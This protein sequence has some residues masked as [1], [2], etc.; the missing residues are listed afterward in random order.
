MKV[1]LIY[2]A[3]GDY[4]DEACM[5]PLSLGALAGLTP[6]DVAVIMYDD[7]LEEIPYD[8]P[9]DLV[10]ISVQIYTARRAY[11]ISAEYRRRGVPVILG[12]MHVTL[13]PEEAAQH[14]DSILI[15]DAEQLWHQVI[16]DARHGGLKP[17]YQGQ[18]CIPQPDSFTRRELYRG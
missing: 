13:L 1:T 16:E 18:P 6:P 2:P 12:G 5:E 10:G 7:R 4:E 15:S 11:E 17:V 3:I 9:T 14:A 8:E